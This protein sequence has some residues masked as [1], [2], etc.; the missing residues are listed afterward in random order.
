MTGFTQEDKDHLYRYFEA[1]KHEVRVLRTVG[2]EVPHAW[3]KG[4]NVSEWAIWSV[5]IKRDAII[6][7]MNERFFGEW[8]SGF[9]DPVNPVTYHQNHVDCAMHF[10]IRGV[11][12]EYNGSQ[13]GTGENSGKGAATDAFK[14][15]AS[16]WGIGLYLQH[17]PQIMTK[18]PDQ[19]ADRKQQDAM[20]QEAMQQVA[21]WIA[22][23]TGQTPQLTSY[24][25]P[26]QSDEQDENPNGQ[27]MADIKKM[28]KELYIGSD[29]KYNPFHHNGSIQKALDNETIKL[30]QNPALASA[31]LF[32][33]RAESE[34][35]Y[36]TDDIKDVLGCELGEWMRSG[37]T[38]ADAWQ[39]IRD[40]FVEPAS[41]F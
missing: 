17:A 40:E 12:M 1:D 11:R 13:S 6:D 22:Q 32:A 31:L 19:F 2:K 8:S 16:Q 37:K 35:G 23:L 33:H 15:V 39:T 10:T 24:Q 21:K 38:I 18:N 3:K 34:Y 20:E 9:L 7:R 4:T 14:R 41:G 5:Y 25:E 30:S 28:T 29:G 26:E 36:S 27:W